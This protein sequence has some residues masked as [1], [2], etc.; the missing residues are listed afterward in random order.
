MKLVVGGR[1][2][3]YFRNGTQSRRG[4]AK[5]SAAGSVA[6]DLLAPGC[7]FGIFDLRDSDFHAM[8]LCNNGELGDQVGQYLELYSGRVAGRQMDC[9]SSDRIPTAALGWACGPPRIETGLD[10]W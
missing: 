4:F 1:F 5:A 10:C 9:P 6:C 2:G 7:G 3:F 8:G